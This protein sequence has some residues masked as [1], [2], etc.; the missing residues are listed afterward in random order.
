M[1]FVTMPVI[2]AG[3][4]AAIGFAGAASAAPMGPDVSHTVENLEAQGF[5][6]IV[7]KTGSA[8]LDQCAVSNVRP[9]QTYERMES[10]IP[11]PRGHTGITTIVTGKTV[12]LDVSC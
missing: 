7:H 10:E 1:K 4:V 12:H 2:A 5:H 11:G 9:G 6:V 3:A 8:P